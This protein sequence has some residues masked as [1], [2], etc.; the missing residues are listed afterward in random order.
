[1]KKLDVF[2][3][4]DKYVVTKELMNAVN[5]SIAQHLGNTPFA[6][7]LLSEQSP[8]GLGLLGQGHE[9]IRDG[10]ALFYVLGLGD[11]SQRES[12]LLD[13]SASLTSGPS[14]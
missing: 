1:M 5:V 11:H 7:L 12:Y 6:P 3:G 4:S 8:A 13:G 10:P 2:K 9:T 14:L